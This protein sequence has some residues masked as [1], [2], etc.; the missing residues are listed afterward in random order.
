MKKINFIV[1][2]RSPAKAAVDD[3]PEEGDTKRERLAHGNVGCTFRDIIDDVW[4]KRLDLYPFL[5]FVHRDDLEY[6]ILDTG[7]VR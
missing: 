7:I 1:V 3:D 2:H 6:M 5:K 4:F